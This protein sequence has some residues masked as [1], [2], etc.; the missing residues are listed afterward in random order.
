MSAVSPGGTLGPATPSAVIPIAIARTSAEPI[1]GVSV[2]FRLSH[3]Q[4]AS[5]PNI[6]LGGFLSAS[7][8]SVGGPYV[9]DHGDGSYT[10]DASTL[11]TP[12]G[13]SDLTGELFRVRVASGELVDAGTLTVTSVTLRDCSNATLFSGIGAAAMVAIDN[14]APTVAVSSPNGGETWLAGS[15]QAVQW[16]AAD[17]AG[18]P[19]DGVDLSYSS[20]GGGTWNAIATGLA[21]AGSYSWTVP[22]T[23]SADGRVRVLARD[24]NGNAASDVSD[25]SFTIAVQSVVAVASSENPSKF[26]QPVSFTAT[27]TPPGAG[28]TVSFKVDGATLGGPVTLH[29]GLATSVSISS[30]AAGTHPVQASYGGDALHVG[31]D[32]GL[33]G[34]QVVENAL[35]ATALAAVPSPSVFGVEVTLTATVTRVPPAAG[36]PSGDV[37]FLDGVTTLATVA[38]DASGAATASVSTLAVGDHVLRAG[39][40]GLG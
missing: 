38:L 34:G 31:S 17:A 36:A 15:S 8:A 35:T 4:L 39:Y 1:A 33:S 25:A 2:T 32:A 37:V 29:D 10:V 27:V 40:A 5:A 3:L 24:V 23:L 9:T 21:N 20:D 11:G 6:T 14:L 28:G 16:S 19:A 30:L 12:C 7:G 18:I 13:S 26:G 22:S